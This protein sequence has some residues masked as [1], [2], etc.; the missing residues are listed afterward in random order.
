MKHKLQNDL[1]VLKCKIRSLWYKCLCSVSQEVSMD[2]SYKVFLVF[3][4]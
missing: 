1:P 3:F 2:I 4:V